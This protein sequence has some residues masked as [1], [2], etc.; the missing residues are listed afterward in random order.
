MPNFVGYSPW[1]DAGNYGEGLGRTLGEAM[2]QMP[3]QRAQLA[4]Q[5][6]QAAAQQ[7]HQLAQLQQAQQFHADEMGLGQSRLEAEKSLHELQMLRQQGIL[8]AA[9]AKADLMSQILDLKKQMADHAK[10]D[11]ITDKETGKTY[12]MEQTPQGWKK[13]YA[14][15]DA[16]APSLGG[17]IVPQSASERENAIKAYGTA[18]STVGSQDPNHPDITRVDP[19]FLGMLSNKV[20]QAQSPYPM[21]FGAP[22]SAAV[23]PAQLGLPQAA[24]AVM[25][26]AIAAPVL[27]ATNA[28]FKITQVGQ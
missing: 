3:Q 17:R 11:F 12:W 28:P 27:G 15:E 1:T 21:N 14:E 20:Y 8:E 9:Q 22:P 18:L 24:P 4:M 23:Q 5:Q 7:Q 13:R 16:G 6:A 26:N 19:K 2:I 10:P 25:T